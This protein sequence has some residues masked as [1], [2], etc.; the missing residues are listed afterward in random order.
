MDDDLNSQQIRWCWLGA[1][2]VQIPD[3]SSNLHVTLPINVKCDVDGL[4]LVGLNIRRKLNTPRNGLSI[5]QLAQ[6]GD[7]AATH[8]EHL[9]DDSATC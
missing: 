3:V 5:R 2:F 7:S 6:M 8:I 9:V 1:R 4:D